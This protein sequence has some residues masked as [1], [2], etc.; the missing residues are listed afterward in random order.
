M[1]NGRVKEARS[2]YEAE[3][4]KNSEE[5]GAIAGLAT[6]LLE[7]GKYEEAEKRSYEVEI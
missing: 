3:L 4:N 6:V 1:N 2:A 5:Y 7:E